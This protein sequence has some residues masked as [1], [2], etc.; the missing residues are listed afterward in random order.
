MCV[1]VCVCRYAGS[2]IVICMKNRNNKPSS[3]SYQVFITQ[4]LTKGRE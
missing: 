2:I 3:H 1:C 4:P